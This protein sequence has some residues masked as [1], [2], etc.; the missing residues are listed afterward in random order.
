MTDTDTKKTWEELYGGDITIAESE[1]FETE[2]GMSFDDHAEIGRWRTNDATATFVK[3][4]HGLALSELCDP[5]Y[6]PPKKKPK[7]LVFSDTLLINALAWFRDVQLDGD[8]T[9][10]ETRRRVLFAIEQSSRDIDATRWLMF[11][12]FIVKR[13]KEPDLNWYTYSLETGREEAIAFGT[14][15]YDLW[16]EYMTGEMEDIDE[17]HFSVP[18]FPLD[19]TESD[20]AGET[21]E[22]L[23]ATE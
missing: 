8:F 3:N 5:A 2:I 17:E 7:D 18:S 21:E 4:V 6:M 9:P 14:E 11:F 1:L 13:R 22:Q 12:G 19:T 16:V 23:E 20:S 15:A 10:V